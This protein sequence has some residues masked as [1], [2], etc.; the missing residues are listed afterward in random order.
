MSQEKDIW[1]QKIVFNKFIRIQFVARLE[2]ANKTVHRTAQ[3]I[4][5]GSLENRNY[6]LNSVLTEKQIINSKHCRIAVLAEMWTS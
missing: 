4:T 1:T 6:A 5:N 2:Y 3:A